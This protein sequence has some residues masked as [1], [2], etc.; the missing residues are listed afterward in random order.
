MS[1]D[2]INLPE[3]AV[4]S[5]ED[6]K[7]FADVSSSS[8]LPRL[9]LMTAS[10]KKCKAKEFP[11]DNYAL[12]KGQDYQD[13][14]KSVDVIPIAWRPKALEMLDEVIAVYDITDAE[15][16]RIKEKSG[17]K[18]SGCMF[19]PEFL[20][21]SKKLGFCTFFMGSKSARRESDA[22]RSLMKKAAT[23]TSRFVETPQY[24]WQTPQV[25]TCSSFPADEQP[26]PEEL[27]EEFTK[28][29]N[30][31]VNDVEVAKDADTASDR[32]V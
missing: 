28:F 26:D 20:L 11:I 31:P 7:A 13:V 19:G 14:G 29:K 25:L 1:E 2:L 5:T 6:D 3:A 30:P 27:M 18:D 9:Q 17:V 16:T 24:S 10:S 32:E 21:W 4:T 23:L 15:F 8:Y 12:V 22:L